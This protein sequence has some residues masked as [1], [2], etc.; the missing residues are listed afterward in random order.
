MRIEERSMVRGILASLIVF[1]SACA[2]E[3]PPRPVALDPSNPAAPESAPLDAGS[4]GLP[5]P[6]P[7]AV[8][9]KE[10]Q[11]AETLYTCPMHPEVISREPGTCPKCGMTLVP[12]QPEGGKP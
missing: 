1:V 10:G 7:K 3:P 4:L 12:K 6:P 8:E 11:P 2:T 9:R 5:A